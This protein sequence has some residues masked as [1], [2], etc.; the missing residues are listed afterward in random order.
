LLS[1]RLVRTLGIEFLTKG[2]ESLLL[3]SEAAGWRNDCL[4]LERAVHTLVTAILLR[5]AGLDTLW[6]D[7]EADPPHTQAGQTEKGMVYDERYA[8]IRP[9]SLWQSILTE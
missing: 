7:T 2:V 6:A 3:G 4:V 9:D 1:E 8:I 5:F